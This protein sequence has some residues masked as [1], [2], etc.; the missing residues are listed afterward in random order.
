MPPHPTTHSPPKHKQPQTRVLAD[1]AYLDTTQV[2][3]DAHKRLMLVDWLV[4]VVDEF[5]L[6]Q[7]TLYLAVALL[8]RFMSAKPVL[9][10]QL[11]LLGVT[12]L[13]V[14]AKFEEVMPPCLQVGVWGCA[15]AA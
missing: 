8:D 11:Q 12:C 5:Q 14:A 6:S 1:A 7:E 10:C 15:C 3:V 2:E 4:E 13:W 9:C